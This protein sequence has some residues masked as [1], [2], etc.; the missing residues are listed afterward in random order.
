MMNSKICYSGS[1]VIW[2]VFSQMKGEKE[3]RDT[4]AEILRLMESQGQMLAQT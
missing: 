4:S 3:L 1:V 2:R